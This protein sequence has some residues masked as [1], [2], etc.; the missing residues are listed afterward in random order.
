MLMRSGTNLALI[1]LA[2][3]LSAQ[4]ALGDSGLSDDFQT[5][6]LDLAS[7]CPCQINLKQSPYAF[8]SDPN[9]DGDRLLSIPVD[10]HSLGGNECHFKTECQPSVTLGD[11]SGA[12]RATDTKE[13]PL[14]PSVFDDEGREIAARKNPYCTKEVTAMALAAKEE[15][16]CIQ[17]QEVRLQKR[18]EHPATDRYIYEISFRM[19]EIVQDRTN[20]IRWVIGQW[21]HDPESRKY[22]DEFGPRWGASP[23]LAQRYDD[24]VLHITV[25]DEHCRCLV[26]SAPHPTRKF[27]LA[28]ANGKPKECKSTHPANEGAACSARFSLKFGQNPMLDSPAGQFV[29]MKYIVQAN[30]NSPAR[31]DVFQNGRPIVTVLGKIGYEVDPQSNSKTKFKIGH[32]RDYMPHDYVIDIDRITVQ[33]E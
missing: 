33:K 25:Q 20:S 2:M 29:D 8:P 23:F 22:G 10:I 13:E 7:W 18:Q 15:G 12:G 24:G 30:R 26:A 27:D 17:R 21:K 6:T 28:D 32:Y 16:E 19:P 3:V 11:T 4:P 5:G 14:G 9:D 31:I 1:L